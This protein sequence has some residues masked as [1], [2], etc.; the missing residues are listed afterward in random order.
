MRAG[1]TPSFQTFNFVWQFITYGHDRKS[2]HRR[3]AGRNKKKRK[4]EE[5]KRARKQ[6]KRE[7]REEQE[8]KESVAMVR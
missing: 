6:R 4:E 1:L 3:V 5:G 8:E 2:I 7:W